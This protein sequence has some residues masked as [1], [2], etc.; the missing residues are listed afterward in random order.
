MNKA[1]EL[2]TV[3][4]EAEQ[5]ERVKAEQLLQHWDKTHQAYVELSKMR[6]K[7]N[8]LHGELGQTISFNRELARLGLKWAEVLHFIRGD[9]I[10]AVDNYK[11]E[12]PAKICRNSGC[13]LRSE[14]GE[15]SVYFKGHKARYQ[16]AEAE[17]CAGCDEPLEAT[18]RSTSP[19]DLRG[20]FAKYYVGAGL[21]N[22]R[23]VWFQEPVP[24]STHDYGA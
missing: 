13:S 4:I 8:N 15:G 1:Q 18:T 6:R 23:K 21:K 24:P 3:L 11:R 20:K 5:D 9:Q 22:G 17:N 14:R 12:T 2:V 16:P 19:S 10:G 7:V